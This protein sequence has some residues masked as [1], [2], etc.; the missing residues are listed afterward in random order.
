MAFQK[1][2]EF[3]GMPHNRTN[4][5]KNRQNRIIKRS[6]TVGN[7]NYFLHSR[8]VLRK[9]KHRW[10]KS[11][12]NSRIFLM[13]CSR[14]TGKSSL[15]ALLLHERAL[16]FKGT[17]HLYVAPVKTHLANYIRPILADLYKD[18][19]EDLK[20]KFN[21]TKCVLRFK[22]GSS[23]YFVGSNRE[24]YEAS[25]RSF[26]LKTI[27]I[28]EA[29]DI[30]HFQ[31]MLESA[32][33]PSVFDSDG[34]LILSSTPSKDGGDELFNVQERLKALGAYFHNTV[35]DVGYP[36]ER[37]AEFHQETCHRSFDV[38]AKKGHKPAWIREYLAEWVKDPTLLIIPEFDKS[39]H[40]KSVPKD[41]L[42][43]P[44]Y[45]KLVSMDQGGEGI[46][47]T[48]ITFG[49]YAYGKTPALIIERSV[50]FQGNDARIDIIAAKIKQ[51]E[52]VLQYKSVFRRTADTN[53]RISVKS[54]NALYGFNFTPVE[55]IYGQVASGDKGLKAMV[56][57][58]RV[59]FTTDPA[60]IAIDPACTELIG[61]L[62]NCIWD[63]H[64]GFKRNTTY[65]HADAIAS[66]MYMIRH[67]PIGISPFPQGWEYK[68][69]TQF[70][71]EM[72]LGKKGSPDDE[73]WGGIFKHLSDLEG[74]KY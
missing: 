19:P 9:M 35:N 68:P 46:D 7:L 48:V 15:G 57:E 33:L 62:E 60:S 41:R 32:A 58:M 47:K 71:E 24:T 2:N 53:D 3:A 64:G 74:R 21:E 54:L 16:Q 31:D 5:K 69:T 10:L 56:E 20:P 6:W 37:I 25:I 13:L 17:D 43:F 67:L 61:A 38:C 34:Y 59:W 63:D 14:R 70:N 22:N 44:F 27:F 55:K 4:Q 52:D 45:H 1:G 51:T 39:L 18:V 30:D 12:R 36:P 66:L 8:P 40:V 11:M 72:F 50:T 65:G 23:I 26:R 42:L 73:V 28:D 29:R 49:Y